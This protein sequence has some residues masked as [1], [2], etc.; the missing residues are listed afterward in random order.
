MNKTDPLFKKYVWIMYKCIKMGR[1][2]VIREME[3]GIKIRYDYTH[4]NVSRVVMNAG[5]SGL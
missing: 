3:I 4:T 1:S 5:N 2:L